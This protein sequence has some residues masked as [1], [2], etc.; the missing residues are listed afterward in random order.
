M[1]FNERNSIH[2]IFV[3]S[4]LRFLHKALDSSWSELNLTSDLILTKFAKFL[5]NF[6]SGHDLVFKDF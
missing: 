1:N 3:A 5:Q 2:L 6:G 4:T